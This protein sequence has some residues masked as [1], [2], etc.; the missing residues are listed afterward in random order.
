MPTPES[1]TSSLPGANTDSNAEWTRKILRWE[2][3]RPGL[4]ED[5]EHMKY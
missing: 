4:I 5:L 2:P 3:P 1:T